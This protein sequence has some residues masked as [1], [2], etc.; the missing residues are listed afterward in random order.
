LCSV[1]SIAID[2]RLFVK[3]AAAANLMPVYC[4]IM[5]VS[6]ENRCLHPFR[7]SLLKD[8][9]IIVG[10]YFWCQTFTLSKNNRIFSSGANMFSICCFAEIEINTPSTRLP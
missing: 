4:K 3:L 9:R 2:N 7:N 5:K 8:N 1:Q 10:D 6:K